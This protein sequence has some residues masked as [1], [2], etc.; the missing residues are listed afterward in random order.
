[1]PAAKPENIPNNN[2]V[3]SAMASWSGQSSYDWYDLSSNNEEYLKP[4]NLS[5]MISG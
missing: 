3:S 5:E 4:N 1:L 2:F